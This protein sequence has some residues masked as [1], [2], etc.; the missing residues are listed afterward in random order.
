MAAISEAEPAAPRMSLLFDLWLINHMVEGAFDDALAAG[1]GL[2][3]EE[4]GFYSLLRRFGPATPGRISRWTAMPPTTVSATVRRLVQ[5]G[6]VDQR[7]NPADGRSRLVALTPDG[8]TAHAGA[9]EVFWTATRPL[10]AALQDDV[11]HQRISLQRLDQALRDVGG[12]EP[13]P[14]QVDD[15]ASARQHLEYDGTPLTTDE[16]G[17]VRAYIDFIRTR[18]TPEGLR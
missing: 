15:T 12:L 10:A 17:S 7:P 18:R 6:H 16:E 9:A 8:V 1:S 2:S 11:H 14:Y 4:F 5:R 3:G 13:R